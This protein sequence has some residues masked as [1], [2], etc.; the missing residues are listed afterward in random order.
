MTIADVF[1]PGIRLL[2]VYTRVLLL[3]GLFC[4]LPSLGNLATEAHETST[5]PP[6]TKFAGMDF[7]N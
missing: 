4:P 6:S 7:S 1:L 2:P 3:D 5:A